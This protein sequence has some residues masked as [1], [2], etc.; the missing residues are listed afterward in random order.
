MSDK[1][2]KVFKSYKEML[3]LLDSRG[4]D[5]SNP[6]DCGRAKKYL[7]RCGYYNLI[8][9][10]KELFLERDACG[11]LVDPEKYVKGA[12]VDQIYALYAFDRQLR[13]NVLENILIIETNIKNLIAYTFSK[14][15]GHK[16]YLIYSN[17]DTSQK[18]GGQKIAALISDI[19]KQI[20]NRSGDPSIS[21]YLNDYGYIPL[22]VLNNIL[23]FGTVSKFY[24][25][26]LPQERAEVAKV[27]GIRDNELTNILSL[28]SQARN[29]CAHSN[30]L[31]CFRTKRPLIDTELHQRMNLPK[32][33]RTHE[34]LF[35]KRDFFS[36]V[37]A[38]KILVSKNQF[39]TLLKQITRGL[40][41]LNSHLTILTEDHILTEMGFPFDWKS[42][43]QTP[44]N[45]AVKNGYSS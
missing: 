16:N 36:V 4:I 34:Y 35:G 40:A 22:W 10:Y 3:A 30:R 14:N 12:T 24:S 31:Y 33:P 25:L 7:Q 9:G 18:D 19:H 37:I 27:F 20:A 38:I 39:N 2:E 26:M 29:F 5:L 44:K 41:I 6:D 42:K 23:T 45:K 11:R 32:N 15:H 28:L 43:L 21:H 13:R 17:F 8:N 1:K